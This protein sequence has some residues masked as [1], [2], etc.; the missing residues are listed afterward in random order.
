MGVY[1]NSYDSLKR[2]TKGKPLGLAALQ[3]GP[4]RGI[5][6]KK[7]RG[8]INKNKRRTSIDRSTKATLILTVHCL[9]AKSSTNDLS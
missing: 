9:I 5:L 4:Q 3:R 1:L 7:R 6:C 2:I 8:E